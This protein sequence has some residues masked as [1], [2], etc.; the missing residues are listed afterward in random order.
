MR[1]LVPFL[2]TAVAAAAIVLLVWIVLDLAGADPGNPVA[3]W[4]RSAA[5]WLSG[6]S[7]GLFAPQ[8]QTVRT[9]TDYGVPAA[10]YAAAAAVLGRY[11]RE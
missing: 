2:R 8:N 3:H 1:G 7:R 5:D 11:Q 10:V 9:L 6:W 4:F